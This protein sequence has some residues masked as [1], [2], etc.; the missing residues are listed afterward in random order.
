MRSNTQAA[1]RLVIDNLRYAEFY[2][3]T[4]RS[5]CSQGVILNLTRHLGTLGLV[6]GD[7]NTATKGETPFSLYAIRRLIG[8]NW[9]IRAPQCLERPCAIYVARPT[10]SAIRDLVSTMR[11]VANA[12]YSIILTNGLF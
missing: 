4:N 2:R 5:V 8:F 10:R 7:G 3:E 12:D 1:E 9:Y 6:K 11:A